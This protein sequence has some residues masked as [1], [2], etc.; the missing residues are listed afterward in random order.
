MTIT[1]KKNQMKQ[2]EEDRTVGYCSYCK[3]LVLE[4]E[5]L[6][7]KNRKK[8]VYHLECWM[9]ENNIAEELNFDDEK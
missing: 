7:F 2:N 1:K 3:E 4:D 8:T 9:S 6:V 5:D